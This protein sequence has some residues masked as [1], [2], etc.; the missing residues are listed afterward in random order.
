MGP[1]DLNP[2][3]ADDRT[4]YAPPSLRSVLLLVLV[5]LLVKACQFGISGYR[6]STLREG[7]FN[8]RWAQRDYPMFAWDSFHY[9]GIV[10]RGYPKLVAAV[11]SDIAFFPLYPMAARAL[12]FLTPEL[13]LLVIANLASLAGLVFFYLWAHRAQGAATARAGLLLALAYPPAYFLSAAYTEGIFFLLFAATCWFL[14]KGKLLPAAGC[15][16]LATATRPT[17]VAVATLVVLWAIFHGES[18]G[19][20]VRRA[21]R[22]LLVG[23]ISLSGLIGYQTY[24]ASRYGRWDAYFTAQKAWGKD[25]PDLVESAE[26]ASAGGTIRP[27]QAPSVLEPPG[28]RK[29]FVPA[30]WGK[31]LSWTMFLLA[32]GGFFLAPASLRVF[33]VVPVLI[34]L[35]GFVPDW[36]H[37]VSSIPR[38]E[39][40]ALPVFLLM[41]SGLHK[42][43][44]R[45]VLGAAAVVGGILQAWAVWQ[46]SA[47]VWCG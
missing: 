41:A 1:A 19:G 17:G 20:T 25:A 8:A 32:V 21:F 26:T 39:T 4:T 44:P 7:E 6:I 46:F 31:P 14:Q 40:A 22:V 15:S 36:G 27:E 45:L 13:A 38:F 35:L 28:W 43:R 30:A 33:Y 2:S 11:P 34:F 24:L 37:R 18:S 10:V 9:R 42:Y 29:V 3:S 12:G 47:G 23:V 16:A 5:I